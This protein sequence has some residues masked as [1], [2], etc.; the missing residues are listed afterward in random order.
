MRH[1]Q[2]GRSVSTTP[3]YN[4]RTLKGAARPVQSTVERSES[5]PP[6]ARGPRVQ[7]TLSW[8][9]NGAPVVR[10]D[11][12]GWTMLVRDNCYVWELL[13]YITQQRAD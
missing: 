12:G 6:L 3:I 4:L 9:T 10:C 8:A 2:Y 1:Y 7:M 13:A 5:A 11:V